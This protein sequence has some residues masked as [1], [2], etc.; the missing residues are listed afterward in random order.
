MAGGLAGLLERPIVVEGG[1][2]VNF[3]EV[4]EENR[5]HIFGEIYGSID[6]LAF[7]FGNVVS[8][9]LMGDVDSET[10]LG[11]PQSRRTRSFENISV[12]SGGSLPEKDDPPGPTQV[13]YADYTLLR[14]DSGVESALFYAKAWS[15]YTKELLAWVDKRLSLVVECAKSF[16]KMA[17][18]AKTL[19]SQ[20]DY[21][22][23]REIYTSA[24]KHDIEYSQV[25]LQTAA[26]LQT[27]KFVQQEADGALRKA[28][29]LLAQRRDEHDRARCSTTRLEE[30]TLAG[31]GKQLEKKR[32]LEEEALQKAE[33]ANDQYKAC[34]A[35][36]GLKRVDLANAKSE[37]LSRI[38][39]LVN[40]CDLTLKAVSPPS[41]QHRNIGDRPR[42]F[43]PPQVTVNWF[44]LQQSQS[45][46]LPMNYQALCETAK[47][48]EPG[49]RYSEFVRTLPKE[50][51]P[52][53]SLSF[54]LHGPPGTGFPFTKRSIGSTHSSHGN[55]SQVSLTSGDFHS[56][57]EVESPVH[58]RAPKIG[59]LRSSSSTDIQGTAN[60]E[61]GAV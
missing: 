10:V 35:D 42:P 21:M 48:Y 15:K 38:R 6:T 49:Q 36:F 51:S 25:L 31:G 43:H 61:S 18:S 32:R 17:E 59:E 13:E 46:S 53:E 41:P 22:P 24:F 60:P 28:R 23:F 33:E 2:G 12:E 39:E 40:Q 54:D 19:A 55:L 4:N 3:K 27:N 16:A 56:A 34:I 1:K 7:T 50:R 5:R 57:D 11:L 52:V 58:R 45:V 20:Q 26:A 37:I 14:S 47:L 8:D 30:E 29:L 9:F 44:Q